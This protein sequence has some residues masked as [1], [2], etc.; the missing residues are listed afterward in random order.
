MTD[1]I[2]SPVLEQ[3]LRHASV[4]AFTDES[5]PL[6]TL[7]TQIRAGQAAATSSFIQA[8]SVVR[9]TRRETR[10]AIA[11][12]AGSRML[13]MQLRGTM[14]FGASRAISRKNSAVEDCEALIIDLSQVRHL[15]VSV[16]LALE[17]AILDM[18]SA[19]RSVYLVG[20]SGQRRD[21][22]EKL[23]LIQQLPADHLLDERSDALQRAITG[24][25]APARSSTSATA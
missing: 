4:R 11:E 5:I 23:G 9:V 10:D 25:P 15:G 18:L 7:K 13:L 16:S 24:L 12:A 14:V 21:R 6:D 19:G 3:Q 17:E 20:A 2:T 1:T 22:L 8:Y